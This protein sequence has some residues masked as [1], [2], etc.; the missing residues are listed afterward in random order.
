MTSCVRFRLFWEWVT[1]C[2]DGFSRFPADPGPPGPGVERQHPL[3]VRAKLH[4]P[5][6]RH[7]PAGGLHRAD[8]GPC[9]VFLESIQV[10]AVLLQIRFAPRQ[11]W[12]AGIWNNEPINVA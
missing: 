9:Q 7:R 5:R 4:L 12:R 8:H 11:R 6:L 1:T 2:S 10:S 3:R